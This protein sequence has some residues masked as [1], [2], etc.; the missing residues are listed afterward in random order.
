LPRNLVHCTKTST[1]SSSMARTYPVGLRVL[2]ACAYKMAT[3][4]NTFL[5]EV[6]TCGLKPT[7]H[8]YS[9]SIIYAHCLLA[10]SY[11]RLYYVL[12]T[13][14]DFGIFSVGYNTCI[15]STKY[16]RKSVNLQPLGNYPHS[17]NAYLVNDEK[18]LTMR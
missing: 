18:Y 8:L 1:H 12:L 10:T 9:V 4:V 6:T 13:V 5:I 17:S 2:Y 16:Q 14:A 3:H 7:K 11:G 15:K